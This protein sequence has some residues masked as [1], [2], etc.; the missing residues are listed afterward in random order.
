M[1]RTSQLLQHTEKEGRAQLTAPC[2]CVVRDAL[3]LSEDVAMR[4]SAQSAARG[5]LR[6]VAGLRPAQRT[7]HAPLSTSP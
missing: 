1:L 3:E 5:F 6:G 4:T 2:S 7:A